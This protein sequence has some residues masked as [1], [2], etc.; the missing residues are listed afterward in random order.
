MDEELRSKLRRFVS[1]IYL[2]MFLQL[3][4]EILP[5]YIFVILQLDLYLTQ[6][7]SLSLKIEEKGGGG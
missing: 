3:E 1:R 5:M 2:G 4:L 6:C 7:D